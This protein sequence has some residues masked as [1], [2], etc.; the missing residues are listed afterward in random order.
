MN[1]FRTKLILA[2]TLTTALAL[3]ADP[4]SDSPARPALSFFKSLKGGWAIKEL[5]SSKTYNFD[6]TYDVGSAGSVVTEQFGKELSVFYADK[7]ELLM[8]HF[9]NRGNQPR[10]KMSPPKTPATYEFE[11]MDITN[12]PTAEAPHVHRIIYRVSDPTH[13][14]LELVWKTGSRLSSEKYELTKK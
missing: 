4:P 8:T 5:A 10:L 12:L 6:M 2:F 3:L 13:L 11:L 14:I 7:G 1:S 9:C